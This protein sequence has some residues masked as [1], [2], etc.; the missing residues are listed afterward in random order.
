[1]KLVFEIPYIENFLEILGLQR[2]WTVGQL[3][4]LVIQ[5]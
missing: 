2:H 3:L 5:P 1:M 4:V